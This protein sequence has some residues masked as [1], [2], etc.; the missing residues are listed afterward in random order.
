MNHFKT[1]LILY[2]FQH[3]YCQSGRTFCSGPSAEKKSIGELVSGN[4]LDDPL[5]A[6]LEAAL[7]QQKASQL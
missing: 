6:C 4:G 2:I 1:L 5:Q 7:G 3:S